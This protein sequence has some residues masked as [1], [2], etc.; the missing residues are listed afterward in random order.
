M[1][2]IIR[3][4][5]YFLYYCFARH[6]PASDRIYGYWA[7]WV[8]F[9]ICKGMFAKCGWG[10]RVEH[11]AEIGT[12]RHTE[13]GAYSGIGIRCR[14]RG[15]IRIGKDVMMGPDVVIL[16]GNHQ[17]DRI[18]IP[19]RLQ[20]HAHAEPV[21][22]GDDVWIGTRA[23]ILPERK[24]GRGAIVAAGAVVTKDVE[25]YAIVGG[26]PARVIGRRNNSE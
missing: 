17:F 15:P 13:I 7:R 10:V 8:R 19:M 9:F 4:I 12:G 18:D 3:L 26:N 1:K 2:K 25:P 21:E 6:L 23:I 5:C 11:G 14:V 20:G 16:G 24:I 22:I